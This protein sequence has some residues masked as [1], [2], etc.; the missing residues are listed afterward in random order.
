MRKVLVLRFSSI[1]DVVLTTPV[2]RALAHAYPYAEVHVATK[3]AFAPLWQCNPY[4]HTVHTLQPGAGADLIRQLQC[5]DFDFI[6]DLHANLRTLR[7]KLALAGVPSRTFPKRNLG[8]YLYTRF[9]WRE[10]LPREHVV[11][12][13]AQALPPGVHLDDSGLDFFAP[14][15]AHQQA[16]AFFQQVH[17]PQTPYAV[18]LGGAHGTKR[19]PPDLA[20]QLVQYLWQLA[21]LPVVLIGGASERPDAQQIKDFNPGVP[22]LD[23]TGQL[24]LLASGALL[25]RTRFAIANDT[26]FMHIAAA[27]RKPTFVLWGNTTPR[28]GMYPYGTWYHSFEVPEAELPC[29]PCSKLGYPMCP[30]GHFRCMRLQQPQAIAQTVLEL[31]PST[32]V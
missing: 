7:I 14:P 17:W 32:G 21:E 15:E 12:R 6:V 26:G 28:L 22:V 3:A 2:V 20:A 25:Q 9:K 18:V 10:A 11:Q 13:Y 4:I 30:Q 19:Y 8:K 16:E 1:G 31:L 5:Q 27:L 29:R 23:T 24:G